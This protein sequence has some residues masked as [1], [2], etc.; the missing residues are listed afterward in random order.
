[1]ARKRN[2][3]FISTDVHMTSLLGVSREKATELITGA[4]TKKWG[5]GKRAM[6]S[7][8]LF[9]SMRDNPDEMILRLTYPLSGDFDFP[10]HPEVQTFPA[11][12]QGSFKR[13][14]SV[15]NWWYVGGVLWDATQIYKNE[16][17]ADAEESNDK[18]GVWGHAMDN[19]VYEGIYLY[20]DD[21]VVELAI[22]S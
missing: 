12:E 1:M 14:E 8:W 11:A 6:A 13:E 3:I 5:G 21:E 19:L 18:Y 16:I 4:T 7:R 15:I 9:D 17:Y 20:P 10:I 2:E 22:G